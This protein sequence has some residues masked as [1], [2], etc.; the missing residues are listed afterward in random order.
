MLRHT[1]QV[2]ARARNP[3]RFIE[4][5]TQSI[6]KDFQNFFSKVYVGTER[7]EIENT[8]F[9]FLMV[10]NFYE[11]IGDGV[12]TIS[13]KNKIVTIS[14]LLN[15]SSYVLFWFLLSLLIVTIEV[16]NGLDD[17]SVLALP[18]LWGV[19]G[20]LFIIIA[21]VRFRS[22]IVESVKSSQGAVLTG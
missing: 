1:S 7:I 8:P 11:I 17:L 16:Y 10:W 13:K 18:L 5:F 15:F 6:E 21:Q 2:K 9:S 4:C 3:E 20:L 14:Y 22:K 12:V 19:I